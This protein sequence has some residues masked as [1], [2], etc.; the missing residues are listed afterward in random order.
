M[1]PN[2]PAFPRWDH[3]QCSCGL[4]L[5]KTEFKSGMSVRTY[6][7]IQA[8]KGLLSNSAFLTAITKNNDINLLKHAAIKHAD[9]LLAELNKDE[10]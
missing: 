3:E 1:N 2:D 8:M 10:K 6:A 4:L 5:A 9:Q 7:A